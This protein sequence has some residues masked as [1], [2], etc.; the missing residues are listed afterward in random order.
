MV[1]GW[2]FAVGECACCQELFMFNPDWVPSVPLDGVRRP[3]CWDCVEL[4]NPVRV[5][6]GLDPIR[7]HPNAYQVEER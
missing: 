5:A 4:V 6:N 2:V 1:T 3:I 7:V